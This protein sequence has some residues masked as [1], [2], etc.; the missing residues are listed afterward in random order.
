MPYN[1]QLAG[2]GLKVADADERANLNDAITLRK[3]CE[4]QE[5]KP[6]KRAE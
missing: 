3:H 5:E 1:D 4:T 2:C 6:S